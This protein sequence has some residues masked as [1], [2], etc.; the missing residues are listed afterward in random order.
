MTIQP[1]FR[2]LCGLQLGPEVIH[3]VVLI[4]EALSLAQP[5]SVDDAGVIQRIRDHRVLRPEQRLEQAAVG[6]E[7][8]RVEDRVFCPQKGADPVLQILVDTLGAA[9]KPDRCDSVAE[10]VE[11][12]VRGVHNVGVIGETQVVV[13]A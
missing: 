7:A 13:R 3:I 11:R 6:I 8:R 1:G 5:D 2:V 10:C 4:A 12:L 9:D